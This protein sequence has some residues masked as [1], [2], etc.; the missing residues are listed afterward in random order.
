MR[1]SGERRRS[2]KDTLETNGGRSIP[3]HSSFNTLLFVFLRLWQ[4][5]GSSADLQVRMFLLNKCHP[6][7][8]GTGSVCT[9]SSVA[10]EGTIFNQL[11]RVNDR[12]DFTLRILH[13][14][15]IM[16][17]TVASTDVPGQLWPKYQKIQYGRTARRLM[18]GEAYIPDI[19]YT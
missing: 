15:G 18:S 7:L 8:A 1:Q 17:L 12:H 13:P 19:D 11:A 5:I 4:F 9:S 14:E 6:A 3:A 16:P 2:L 10:V